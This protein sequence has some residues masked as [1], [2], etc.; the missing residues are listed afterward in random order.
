MADSWQTIEQAAV[1]LRLSVRTVNRH[2]A[3]GKLQSRLNADGRREVLVSLPDGPAEGANPSPFSDTLAADTPAEVS[4]NPA[5]AISAVPVP[6]TGSS[7][8][9]ET[10]LALADSAAQKADMAVTAYQTL[11][12]LADTQVRQ[13]RRQARVAWAAVALM[14]AGVTVAVGWTTHRLTRASA[15]A[16]HLNARLQQL[17]NQAIE[18]AQAVR[19]QSDSLETERSASAAAQS[20]LR[21]ELAGAREQAARADGALAAYKQHELA[22]Q[23]REAAAPVEPTTRLAPSAIADALAKFLEFAKPSQ[24]DKSDTSSARLASETTATPALNDKALPPT[25]R[26]VAPRRKAA[27]P[28]TAPT[29]GRNHTSVSTDD[30]D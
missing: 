23:T 27:Q 20:E 19:Q 18:D 1:S 11:A 29:H 24:S 8:D 3:A 15:D 30:G 6:N 25:T 10:V 12:R 9:P 2:M 17:Q 16:D 4:D 5:P 14:A 28:T 13:V 7:L 22:R 21:A 26:P